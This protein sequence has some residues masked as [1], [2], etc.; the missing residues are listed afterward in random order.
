[1]NNDKV[2]SLMGL[3][4]KA[5]KL[6]SG[7]YCVENE[8]K[9]GKAILVI[10]AKDASE[11][12]KKKYSDMCAYRQVPIC[13]YSDKDNIGRCLGYDER[14]AAVITDEGFASGIMKEIDKLNNHGI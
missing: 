3:A 7:E 5:G 9:K 8:I 6:K 12:T 4:R 14:A 13:F 10:V 1:M 11:N 2:L